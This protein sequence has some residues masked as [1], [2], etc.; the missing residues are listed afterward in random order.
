MVWGDFHMNRA[1]LIILA[2]LGIMTFLVAGSVA[3]DPGN[4]GPDDAS[5]VYDGNVERHTVQVAGGGNPEDDDWFKIDLTEGH[6]LKL[7]MVYDPSD[8]RAGIQVYGPDNWNNL[9][10]QISNTDLNAQE[11]DLFVFHNGTY[12]IRIWVIEDN[13]AQY[14]MQVRVLNPPTIISDTSVSN[15]GSPLMG[16]VDS[17]MWYKLWLVGG[18]T[19]TEVCDVE[20]SW[21][22][23][24]NTHLYVHD[25]TDDYR[26]GMLNYSW[27][28]SYDHAESCRFAA[29]YT[30]WYFIKAHTTT[31]YTDPSYGVT[32]TLKASIMTSKHSA[33]G[34]T[35]MSDAVHILNHSTVQGS[36][37][38]AFDTHEWYRFNLGKGEMFSAKVTITDP[39]M[40]RYWDYYNLTLFT[41]NGTI[42]ASGINQGST[43]APISTIPVFLGVAPHTGTFFLRFSAYYGY[44]GSGTTDYTNGN[45]VNKCT[46][47]IDVR[48]PNRPVWVVDPPGDIRINE[49]GEYTLDLTTV[50][51]DP[52]G[53]QMTYGTEGGL[54]NFTLTV[55]QSTGELTFR[56]NRNWYG[57]ESIG[58]W[59]HDGRP[60]LKNHTTVTITVR[61]EPDAPYVIQGAPVN[62][63]IYEDEVNTTALNM[64]NVFNDVDI[65]DRFLDFG[66]E[67]NLYI[68][69]LINDTSGQ[70]TIFAK[71]NYTGSQT[72]LFTAR[73]SYGIQVSH[74]LT[75]IVL[76]V[77]DAPFSNGTLNTECP[78]DGTTVLDLTHMFYD[79]D[80]GP[81]GVLT[82]GLNNMFEASL[83]FTINQVRGTMEIS[84]R[85]DVNGNFTIMIWCHDD[86]EDHVTG[87]IKLEVWPVNDIP[88]SMGPIPT[89]EIEEGD[90]E[91]VAIDLAP[92]FFDADGDVLSFSFT[93]VSEE[94]DLVIIGTKDDGPTESVLRIWPIDEYVN[95]VVV[96]LCQCTDET[97]PPVGLDLVIRVSPV[98]NPPEIQLEIVGDYDDID[99]LDSVFF[100]VGSVIDH[101]LPEM[102]LE[103]YTW[104][105]NDV[106]QEGH[107]QSSLSIEFDYESA[108]TYIVKV[109]VSDPAGLVA[110]DVPIWEFE[111]SDVNR[112]PLVE[113]VTEP[114]KLNE[115]EMVELSA[116]VSDPDGDDLT[117]KWY[118]VKK[119]GRKLLGEGS[120]IT[121]KLPDGTRTVEVS[122]IDARGGIANDTIVVEVTPME[123][124]NS[125]L[126]L[127]LVVAVAVVTAA[128]GLVIL[129]RRNGE[130]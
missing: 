6:I 72:C 109:E 7:G 67:P 92:Y 25:R 4:E 114:V 79:I 63:S 61:N 119:D 12:Y 99:E 28:R 113:I 64:Y 83:V 118:L 95:G 86:V 129:R 66:Y 94:N 116:N 3:A 88:V 56:P 2:V 13:S 105:V 76:D 18:N 65:V 30:G 89:V 44:S 123:T 124:G 27:S 101:D 32:F 104:Y 107:N 38:Q 19:S 93:L 102:G 70:T 96:V 17:S 62:I 90:M 112:R 127:G 122:V 69:V 51:W 126:F 128:V 49:D 39:D 108:G 48:I 21:S 110:L 103:T 80:P 14:Q 34:N 15:S 23:D 82:Y 59:A 45:L 16:R 55:D 78:E 35:R 71:A 57:S 50:F 75:I 117:I 22:G 53:D 115:N 5:D 111:V 42:I 20:M 40:I 85:Q 54:V 68:S 9:L 37:D 31:A 91:G 29:S 98:P 1:I 46:F 58:I 84:P 120:I 73:D 41:H 36:I 52:E 97:G 130:G 77:R 74:I 10:E 87:T 24:T 26:L 11:V 43:G 81:G 125:T 8:G 100:G 60:D 121:T 106:K 47:V 33:D